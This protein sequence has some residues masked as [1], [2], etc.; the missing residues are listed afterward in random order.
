[1]N[2]PQHV[3]ALTPP[4]HPN[5]H[6][7]PSSENSSSA[8]S[9]RIQGNAHPTSNIAA[10]MMQLE[11]AAKAEPPVMET[12]TRKRTRGSAIKSEDVGQKV[13]RTGDSTSPSGQTHDSADSASVATMHVPALQ[14]EAPQYQH[15][16]SENA[17]SEDD[18]SDGHTYTTAAPRERRLKS[19]SQLVILKNYYA[20]HPRVS[21]EQVRKLISQTGLTHR[22]VTRWFRNERHK[23]KKMK[24][25][26]MSAAHTVH[27]G[28]VPISAAQQAALLE[29]ERK[30]G[31]SLGLLSHGSSTSPSSPQSNQHH[32][33]PPQ[34]APMPMTTSST[35]AC[36]APMMMPGGPSQMSGMP[37]GNG[38]FGFPGMMP[39]QMPVM[40]MNGMVAMPQQQMDMSMG[41]ASLDPK[42]GG[43]FVVS[44]NQQQFHQQSLMMQQLMM[45]QRMLQEQQQSLYRH[46]MV[47]PGGMSHPPMT[48][49]PMPV[50][51]APQY[52]HPS[53]PMSSF[54]PP[55]PMQPGQ[56]Q[57]QQQAPQQPSGQQ[58]PNNIAQMRL[59]S[60]QQAA[61]QQVAAA[62][63]QAQHHVASV[64]AQ[65]QAQV[66]AA[67]AQAVHQQQQFTSAM[68]ATTNLLM[69]GVS[70]SS[71]PSYFA[72]AGAPSLV[73]MQQQPQQM[74]SPYGMPAKHQLP[75]MPP[76]TMMMPQ[77]SS[78]PPFTSP[79]PPSQPAPHPLVQQ[80]EAALST[81]AALPSDDALNT[82]TSAMLAV[83]NNQAVEAH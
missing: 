58:S 50:G 15:E 36:F 4:Y 74:V 44:P 66:A 16:G 75:M 25:H 8:S 28:H 76:M 19:L 1:M 73:P 2:S 24:T 5:E 20:L 37:A 54:P 63:A 39:M 59:A 51:M 42:K 34:S 45:Q 7:A 60:T 56:Q 22:E 14:G 18:G 30:R 33:P 27:H 6:T 23:E 61:Q 57:Q 9:P 13:A 67:Q 68:Q 35:G 72:S 43:T 40:N 29:N 26:A 82:A 71:F 77:P 31:E 80:P 47:G 52:F 83:A 65:A 46:S 48:M 12:S 49:Q 69:Q 32:A 64:Q 3:A 55:L 38:Q 17:G 79:H 10:Q 21:K 11:S 70:P 81:S 62:Q 78:S 53:M 41:M